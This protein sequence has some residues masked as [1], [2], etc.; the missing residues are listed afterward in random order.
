MS[1]KKDRQ[2]VCRP[3]KAVNA[4]MHETGLR[5]NL[6]FPRFPIPGCAHQHLHNILFLNTT[7]NKMQHNTQVSIK[8]AFQ[9]INGN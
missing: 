2:T 9:L 3:G 8:M 4:I 7:F 5:E 6:P 1:V